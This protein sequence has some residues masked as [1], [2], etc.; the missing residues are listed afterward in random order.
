MSTVS[1]TASSTVEQ[2]KYLKNKA[3]NIITTIRMTAHGATDGMLV[4][5]GIGFLS[6][7]PLGL[8]NGAWIGSV[9]GA[10]YG[11]CKATD[12]DFDR[13]SY[14]AQAQLFRTD[15]SY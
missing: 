15:R 14:E 7:G 1:N 13:A 9:V 6:A 5:A 11:F 4:G 8:I 12:N 10:L 2:A 3:I